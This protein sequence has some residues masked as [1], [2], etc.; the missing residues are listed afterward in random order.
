VVVMAEEQALMDMPWDAFGVVCLVSRP[1][2]RRQIRRVPP[3]FPE[4]SVKVVNR[5]RAVSFSL[6]MS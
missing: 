4:S 6:T 5:R 1:R 3:P 2:I